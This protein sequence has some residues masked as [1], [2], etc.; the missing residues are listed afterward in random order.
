MEL[1]IGKNHLTETAFM[2]IYIHYMDSIGCFLTRES[3]WR[4]RRK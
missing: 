4:F 3:K 1:K 2:I